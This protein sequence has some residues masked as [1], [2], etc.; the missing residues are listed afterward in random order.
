MSINLPLTIMHPAGSSVSYKTPIFYLKMEEGSGLTAFDTSDTGNGHDASLVGTPAW[1]ATS[2]LTSPPSVFGDYVL[3]FNGS[4][5]YLTQTP[6]EFGGACSFSFWTNLD[7]ITGQDF[8]FMFQDYNNRWVY[9]S[10]NGSDLLWTTRAY[11]STLT[12]SSA[13]STS[14]NYHI[15]CTVSSGGTLKVYMDNSLSGT[16]TP[17]RG[18]LAP[19]VYTRGSHFIGDSSQFSG[20]RINGIMDEFS[21]WDVELS[22]DDVSALYNSGNGADANTTIL[23]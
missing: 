8:F 18:G 17:G 14:T 23:L 11:A 13:L 21:M 6:F 5:D 10:T 15:V 22:V 1:T 16:L 9:C 12:I 4:S 7:A 20:N 19:E 2:G 3:D